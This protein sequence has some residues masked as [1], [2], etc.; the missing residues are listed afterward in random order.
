MVSPHFCIPHYMAFI[1]FEAEITSKR[2]LYRVT[3]RVSPFPENEAS[4]QP[5]PAALFLPCSPGSWASTG[6]PVSDHRLHG[7][8]WTSDQEKYLVWFQSGQIKS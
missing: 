2:K 1:C 7:V 4:C 3:Q 5:I 8:V 6:G